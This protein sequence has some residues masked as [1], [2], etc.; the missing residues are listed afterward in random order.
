[1]IRLPVTMIEEELGIVSD[2][3]EWSKA[4]PFEGVQS[5]IVII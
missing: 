5:E 2:G 4:L 3:V 1:M